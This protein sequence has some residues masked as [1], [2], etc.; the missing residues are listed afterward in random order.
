[1]ALTA[2]HA[3]LLGAVADELQQARGRINGIEALVSDLI[4]QTAPENRA[5]ALTQAQALDVLAQEIE[6]LSGVLRRLGQGAAPEQALDVVTL[7]DL[8]VR[9]GVVV[10]LAQE[11]RPAASSEIELF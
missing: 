7:A 5:S 6:A 4:R 11:H 10:G 8:S 9:L 3:A 2:D 1:M